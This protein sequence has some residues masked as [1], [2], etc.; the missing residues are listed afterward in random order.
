MGG[1]VTGLSENLN[2]SPGC[3][4]SLSANHPDQGAGRDHQGA[5]NLAHGDGPQEEADL[6]IRLTGELD[7]DAERPVTKKKNGQQSSM[8]PGGP[9]LPGPFSEA[10]EDQEEDRPLQEHLVEL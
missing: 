6:V 7:Q 8:V 2:R 10:P 3:W 5:E 9:W 4:L 1:E